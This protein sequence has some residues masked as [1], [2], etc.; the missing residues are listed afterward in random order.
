MITVVN[1]SYYSD[2]SLLRQ[3]QFEEKMDGEQDYEVV[4]SIEN[5]SNKDNVHNVNT[6]KE[7]S[8]KQN[9][10]SNL[11]QLIDEKGVFTYY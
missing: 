9:N 4:N 6:G 1:Q 7:V 3:S 10:D 8:K 11:I 5:S 2:I